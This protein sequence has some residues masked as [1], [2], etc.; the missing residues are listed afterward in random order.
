MSRLS[1]RLVPAFA[2]LLVFAIA[3]PA[4]AQTGRISGTVTDSSSGQPLLGVQLSVVGTRIGAVTG[5]DGRYLLA[6]V[7]AGPQTLQLRRIGYQARQIDRVVVNPGGV[8]TLDVALETTPFT[9]EAQVV[10]GVVDPTSG[11]RTPFTVG[12]VDI[13]DAPVPPSN[14]IETIQG[15]IA[16]VTIVPSGQPG[17]GTNIVLRTPTS[18]NK[19]NTPLIVVDGIILAQ[20]D[21]ANGS[22]ADLEALDIESV[23]VIK[24]AAAAS[25]YGS[26]AAS[27][28]IQIRT[29]RGAALPEGRTRVTARSEVGSNSLAGE[30]DW[31]R[32]HD[33]LQNDAG[34]YINHAGQVVTQATRVQ[35]SVWRRFQDNTYP[36]RVYDQVDA[37]FDPGQFYSNSIALA[38]NTDRTNWRLSYSN[39]REDGVVLDFGGYTQNDARFNLDHRPRSDLTLG[40]SGYVSR[41]KRDEIY[42]DTFFDL[43]NQ[44]PDINLLDPDP[45]GTPFVYMADPQGREENPLY[46]LA[47]E[48]DQL[49]RTRMLGSLNARWAPLSWFSLD[50][51]ASFDRADR[52]RSFFLDRG[53]K[54]E[55]NAVGG[56]TGRVVEWNGSTD[57]LNAAVS[58][59][60]LGRFGELTA[61]TTLRGIMEQQ[62]ANLDLATGENLSVPGVPSLDN[63]QSS[64][65]TSDYEDIRANGWFAITGVEYGGRYIADALVRRDGSS[66]FG[67]DERWHTYYRASGAWRVAEE[68]WWPLPEVEEFKLRLS[69]GTAGGRPDFEDQYETYNFEDGGRI[70]K[71]TLGNKEL[72][73]ERATETEAGLDLIAFERFS[74]QLSYAEN[75]VEDQLVLMPLPALYGFAQQWQNAGTVEG[76]TIEATFEAQM[77]TSADLSWRMGLVFDRTRSKITEFDAP[78]FQ[79]LT[80][81]YRCEG[82]TLGA[83]YGF[84]FIDSPGDLLPGAAAR[85]DEFQVNDDGLLVWVGPGNTFREGETEKL[86]GTATTI[87]GVTYGW[88]MPIPLY[89]GTGS[90]AVVKIGDGNPDYHVGLSNRVTWRDF[91]FYGLIDAQVGGNVYNRTNQRMHQY[92]RSADVDQAGKE[93]ELKKISDYYVALYSANDPTSWFVEDGGF[94]KLRELSV[95]YR[96]P[97]TRLGFLSRSAISGMTLSVVGRNLMTWTDYS[98]YDP[99]V[100][101]VIQRF[102]A[103][104]YPRYR[105]VTGTVELEF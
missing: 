46:V 61:R 30:I 25:L 26:R 84:R 103:F 73:P 9:L 48:Q 37:F 15:K 17:G 42:D 99:E 65:V 100:G 56:F 63:A 23:E 67:A 18:I 62:R 85:A 66:L 2:A 58:A 72:K 43:I 80:I 11:T 78:C 22:T 81:A 104:E 83:M 5:A 90:K 74:L 35:D 33:W 19:S 94:V 14:A 75:V 47:T 52:E 32:Y 91:S 105:T 53:V 59:N 82:V 60:F 77:V 50:G 55:E 34:E 45:D 39:R 57:A 97:V 79:T 36:G 3:A 40:F 102:D 76:N 98:G 24:G 20:S 96:V 51:N 70:V 95:S 87:D 69:R 41:A 29:K 4:I 16:G 1:R 31:A 93:Q 13:A 44:P 10:T 89:T 71:S 28:V 8:T 27:G 12:R 68:A 38:Q 101:G 64:I 7:P 86:W 49:R 54:T 6:N 88:G 21:I 92:G